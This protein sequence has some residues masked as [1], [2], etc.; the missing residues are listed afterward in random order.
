MKCVRISGKNFGFENE[1]ISLPLYAAWL[2]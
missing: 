2:I 1:I